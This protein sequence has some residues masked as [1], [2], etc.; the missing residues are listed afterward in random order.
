MRL[1]LIKQNFDGDT[2]Y[3]YKHINFCCD[4][5]KDKPF[6]ELTDES[7]Y[8]DGDSDRKP[9][10]CLVYNYE[11]TEWGEVMQATTYYPIKYCPFCGES[12]DIEVVAEEDVTEK[13]KSWKRE[14]D[15]LV[16]GAR[17]TDSKVKEQHL[18]KKIQELDD[19]I[20]YLYEI[21]EYRQGYLDD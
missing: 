20:E 18:R 21:G 15:I 4:K 13:Y 8:D 11:W 10:M 5:F 14:Y 6:I 12:I 3:K 16:K 7:Y 19:K 9:R 17:V 2:G 1:E